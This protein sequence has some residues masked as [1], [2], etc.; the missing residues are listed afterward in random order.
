MPAWSATA[1]AAPASAP[2][3][4]FVQGFD[5]PLLAAT[6]LSAGEE[7]DLAEVKR[8]FEER[9]DPEE[10]AVWTAFLQRHPQSALR[11]SLLTNLGICEFRSGKFSRCLQSLEQA[12]QV[13]RE[14]QGDPNLQAI[15]G[16]AA[17]ELAMMYARLGRY[18]ALQG[19]LQATEGRNFR[20]AGGNLLDTARNGFSLMN[21]SPQ[22]S[23]RC[24]PMALSRILA[25]RGQ[26]PFP[27]AIRDSVSTRQGMSL[28]QVRDL[29][30]SLG[31]SDLRLLKRAAAA[32]IALPAVVHWKTGHYAALLRE[33]NGKYLVEDP[34]FS[35][36]QEFWITAATLDEEAS[37]Y[38]LAAW[39]TLPEGW[40]EVTEAEGA[41]VWGKGQTGGSDPN[42]TGPL[43]DKSGG[44][45]GGPCPMAQWQVTGLLVGLQISDTPVG[46]RP[47]VGLPIFA[48]VT[49][50]SRENDPFSIWAHTNLGPKWNLSHIAYVRD[51]GSAASVHGGYG[52]S[53]AY[54]N[55]DS[56]TGFFARNR[57]SYA[58]LQKRVGQAGQFERTWPNGTREYF[59]LV[60]PNGTSY[61]T[62]LTDPYGNETTYHYSTTLTRV[63]LERITDANGRETVF[64]YADG[65]LSPTRITD[66]FGRSA[67]FEYDA[68]GRLIRITDPI[69]ITS[70]FSYQQDSD[71]I[72]ALTTPYGQTRFEAGANG[73]T[74]W[75]QA[76]YPD[77]GAERFEFRH[78][79]DG[80]SESV[81]AVPQGMMITN[82]YMQYRNALHWD[83]K[84]MKEAPGDPTQARLTHYLHTENISVAAGLVESRKLPLEGRVWYNYQGQD[85]PILVSPDSDS[86]VTKIGRLLDDGSTELTQ[87][88]YNEAGRPT[89]H[90]D[91]AGRTTLLVYDENQID[92][93]EVRQKTGPETSDLLASYTYNDR[94][95]VLTSTDAAGNVTSCTYNARGQRLTLTAP[96]GRTT[97]WTYDSMGR[98]LHVDGP[99]AGT[100]DRLTYTH[101]SQDRVESVTDG[102]GLTRSYVYDVIDRI[103][104]VTHGDGAH[105]AWTYQWLNL[106]T[107]R[108]RAGEISTYSFNS[109]GQPTAVT[110]SSGRT[111]ST[112][113][114]ACGSPKSLIDPQGQMTRFTYDVQGRLTAKIHADGRAS[115]RV[116]QPVSGRLVKIIDEE[117]REQS[118]TYTIDGLIETI[119]GGG[120]AP[121]A[122]LASYT[123]DSIYRRPTGF[124]DPTGSTTLT[125]HP[126]VAGQAGAGQLA[127]WNGPLDNDTIEFVY[128]TDGRVSSRSIGGAANVE[129]YTLDVLDRLPG[130]A[131]RLGEF[132]TSFEGGSD[133]PVSHELPNGQLTQFTYTPAAALKRPAQIVHLGPGGTGISSFGMSYDS[134]LRVSGLTRTTDGGPTLTDSIAR[135]AF[136]RVT[137]HERELSAGTTQSTSFTYDAADNRLSETVGGTTTTFT[138]NALNQLVATQPERQSARSYE[139]DA[140]GRLAAIDLGTHRTEFSY[141]A[142]SRRTRIVEKENGTVVTD[143][144]FVFVGFQPA[145]ERN[146]AGTVVK[147]FYHDG[148]QQD[149]VSYY[150]T[151]DP[152]GSIREVCDASGTVVC[153]LTYDTHGRRS[154]VSGTVVPD[155][156]FTGHFTH[157]PSGLVL[158]FAR[159]YD[160]ALGRW[161]SRDPAGEVFGMNLYGYALNDPF[162]FVDPTGFE[163]DY[164]GAFS[165]AAQAAGSAVALGLTIGALA[166]GAVVASPLAAGVLAVVIT[167]QVCSITFNTL[168]AVSKMSGGSSMVVD[169]RGNELQGNIVADSAHIYGWGGECH[170]YQELALQVGGFGA[171]LIFGLGLNSVTKGFTAGLDAMDLRFANG[172]QN[173]GT[174]FNL[175]PP[176]MAAAGTAIPPYSPPTPPA[177]VTPVMN[178]APGPVMNPAPGP[179]MNPAP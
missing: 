11:L 116:Y 109:L 51:L 150:Y 139:W 155:F 107:Y 148:F 172:A 130:L 157:Q 131:N 151:R 128:A 12:W 102:S 86:R 96:G 48:T 27:D 3:L 94:H 129:T 38:C 106:K 79:A 158:T 7:H 16:R 63:R 177:P 17:G 65:G 84:A 70:E 31:L 59:G 71:F 175:S 69:D 166:S 32:K 143:R 25:S 76:T 140:G 15:A 40:S 44:D 146:A 34:T 132:T 162:S 97:E 147:R 87:V 52:G 80:I 1:Q 101:D 2:R 53:E 113:W 5:E 83:R 91:A 61:R 123:W 164:L 108:S 55:L 98:L 133:R 13:G 153:R 8:Q 90:V 126:L 82:Q 35:P 22:T 137:A 173:T 56:N 66:P 4:H 121:V 68:L 45:A 33:Q 142:L 74:R 114:C 165:N 117:G 58:R 125:Y 170:P 92:L 120:T 135:D 144:R 30:A 14:V 47:T 75:L 60:G 176:A 64:E 46:Y 81:A 127:A 95:Q 178:P 41:Q 112:A 154:V 49:Y 78:V 161:I 156:G 160:P 43:A 28:L 159:A 88:E 104:R 168:N 21:E 18:E 36:G 111:T 67:R 20:G 149:G 138:V 89:R 134:Q 105:E 169:A 171:D 152:L 115:Q 124:S 100:G 29:A 50:N 23:F 6:P 110:D 99:L 10:T 37:G 103:T 174:A 167:G 19:L 62:R 39:A 119:T 179:V 26:S 73:S 118:V 136:G 72:E 163:P 145:E 93:L 122:V 141:D 85:N 57:R 9:A 24:G 54:K 42:E 77:G